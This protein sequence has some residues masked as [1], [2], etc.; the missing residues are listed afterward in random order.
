VLSK[1]YAQVNIVNAVL[2]LV[3]TVLTVS[4]IPKQANAQ[5]S[6]CVVIATGQGRGPVIVVAPSGT[7]RLEGNVAWQ[8]LQLRVYLDNTVFATSMYGNSYF[9][10]PDFSSSPFYVVGQHR[11]EFGGIMVES[12]GRWEI[13]ACGNFVYEPTPTPTS[14]P[15][16]TPIPW[17]TSSSLSFDCQTSEPVDLVDVGAEYVATGDHVHIYFDS[18]ASGDQRTIYEVIQP[19][20]VVGVRYTQEMTLPLNHHALIRVVGG[21][22]LGIPWVIVET[23]TCDVPSLFPTPLV[24]PHEDVKPIHVG[25]SYVGTSCYTI[26]PSI[27]FQ[28]SP[29][30]TDPVGFSY[31]GF[32]ICLRKHAVDFRWGDWDLMGLIMPLLMFSFLWIIFRLFRRG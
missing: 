11:L 13:R 24:V 7:I 29:P 18:G 15:T 26:M 6:P 2:V 16:R 10:T 8:G 27:S 3:A 28:V 14:L 25:S 31:G 30:F 5:Q 19:G 23:T 22:G 1:F 21:S 17:P 4:I 32:G 9:S 20:Q 12:V